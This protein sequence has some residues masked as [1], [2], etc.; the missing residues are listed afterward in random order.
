MQAGLRW[1]EPDAAIDIKDEGGR[2]KG[3]TRSKM[4]YRMLEPLSARVV[5]VVV[6]LCVVYGACG[7][8]CVWWWERWMADGDGDG[9]RAVAVG[10]NE[11]GDQHKQPAPA[12][13]VTVN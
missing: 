11:M 10:A 9:C 5:V 8:W 12:P 1:G 7:V 13:A 6:V 2:G 3:E 4:F